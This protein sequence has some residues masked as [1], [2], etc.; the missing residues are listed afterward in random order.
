MK[1][2]DSNRRE[3]IALFRYG[4][5]A[6]LIHLSRGKGSGLYEKL[7]KKSECDWE[8]PFTLRR[9]IA[10]ETMRDWLTAY[11]KGGFDALKPKTRKDNGATRAIPQHVA[12]LLVETKE[13]H[14]DLSV[15]LLVDKVAAELA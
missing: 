6:D 7:H 8:I 13:A 5:I 12:D 4:V 11:R 1:F 3:Q 2:D 15:P 14:R 9:H 10:A